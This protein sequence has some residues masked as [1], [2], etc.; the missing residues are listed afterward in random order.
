LSLLVIQESRR[1]V[2]G[3]EPNLETIYWIMEVGR[4]FFRE[5]GKKRIKKLELGLK[6]NKKGIE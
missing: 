5:S 4:Y 2:L 1:E 6:L 3:L